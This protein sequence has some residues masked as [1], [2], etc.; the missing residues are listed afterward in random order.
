MPSAD[1]ELVVA[2]RISHFREDAAKQDDHL[3]RA[4]IRH[5]RGQMHSLN[6]M[7]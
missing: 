7:T 1:C 3:A 5:L 6:T 4:G 2:I